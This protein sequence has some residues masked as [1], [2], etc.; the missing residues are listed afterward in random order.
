MQGFLIKISIVA[1]SVALAV[2]PR[3][4]Y[5]ENGQAIG[6]KNSAGKVDVASET[7][8]SRP[9]AD[10][11]ESIFERNVKAKQGDIT[12]LCDK[13]VIISDEN[14]GS[15]A[16]ESRTKRLPKDLQ[17]N[18]SI[19]TVTA[20]GSVKITQ[21]DLMATAGKAVYDHAKRTITLTEGP[22]RFWQGRDSGMADAVTMY[23]DENRFVLLKPKFTIEPGEQK[24][25]NKK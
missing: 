11:R 9:C 2:L 6:G 1:L 25:E 23:L 15:A 24:K 7:F 12:L 4:A 22:P 19:K 21:K 5:S 18:S 8:T 10:G 14:K 20:L 3:A 17:M 16:P 13:L